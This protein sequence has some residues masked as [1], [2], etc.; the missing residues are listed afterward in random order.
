MSQSLQEQL[1]KA[2]LIS[3]DRANKVKKEKHQ[4]RQKGKKAPPV[5]ESRRLAREAAARDAARARAIN[6][7]RDE[8]FRQKDAA[9]Q[10]RQLI[11]ENKVDRRSAEIAYKFTQGSSVRQVMVTPAQQEKVVAGQLAIVR[12]K[13]RFELVPKKVAQLIED[14][15]PGTVVALNLGKEQSENPDDPYAEFKVPDDLVW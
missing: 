9:G 12:A 4:N 3:K 15:V 11:H 6:L 13:E 10:V 8:R 7:E 1:L 2:G 5:S 14:R